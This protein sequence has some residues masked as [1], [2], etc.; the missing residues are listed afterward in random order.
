M[1]SRNP[2]AEL[3]T[4]VEEASSPNNQASKKGAGV[5]EALF[6]LELANALGAFRWRQKKTK[7][8][9]RG[10]SEKAMEWLSGVDHG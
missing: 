8:T 1:T 4:T 6:S 3:P 9:G 7:G 5:G 2:S 10:N